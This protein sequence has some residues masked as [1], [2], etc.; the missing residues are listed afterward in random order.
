MPTSNPTEDNKAL[1]LAGIRGVFIV[2]IRPFWTVCSATTISNII[3][4]FQTGPRR[5]SRYCGTCRPIS[6]TSP[7]SWW[8]M[9]TMSWFM[10][11]M[12]DGDQAHGWG[13]YFP[14]GQWQDRRTLGRSSGRGPGGAERQRKRDVHSATGLRQQGWVS[15]AGLAAGVHFRLCVKLLRRQL[16]PRVAGR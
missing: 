15:A 1:V 13:R 16:Q 8:P 11:A 4:R 12:S 7:V 14:R 10:A 9:V 3:R 5:S 6:N 2:A